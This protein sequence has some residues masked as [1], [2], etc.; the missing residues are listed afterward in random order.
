MV[1]HHHSSVLAEAYSHSKIHWLQELTLLHCRSRKSQRHWLSPKSNHPSQSFTPLACIGSV[2]WS[3]GEMIQNLRGAT[4]SFQT[5]WFWKTEGYLH[6][7]RP[8][9]RSLRRTLDW[10]ATGQA[11]FWAYRRS[12]RESLESVFLVR[13][14]WCNPSRQPPG[15]RAQ[16][17][18]RYSR[19]H[20]R[21]LAHWSTRTTTKQ[22]T[23]WWFFCNRIHSGYRSGVERTR[24]P[25]HSPLN[26]TKNAGWYIKIQTRSTQ[27]QIR[28]DELDLHCLPLIMSLA[29]KE[30]NIPAAYRIGAFF[31]LFACSTVNVFLSSS[32]LMWD[33]SK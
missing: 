3:C 32:R 18:Y 30:L 33:F 8:A 31:L 1:T 21:S 17:L 22:K 28:A 23:W 6:T 27:R 13:P 11:S 25:E 19:H 15:N 10:Q 20:T 7:L 26:W 5:D 16:F 29:R 9:Y 14:A 12:P 2:I 4:S 24:D